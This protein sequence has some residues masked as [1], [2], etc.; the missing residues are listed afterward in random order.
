M[1]YVVNVT[2]CI[3]CLVTEVIYQFGGWDGGQDLADLWA[4]SV[5]AEQWTCISKNTAEEGG[6]S[7]RSCHKMCLDQDRKQIFTLGR[8]LDSTCR[9]PDNLKVL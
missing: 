5:P 8:Y 6:P 3:H 7:A 9:T 4:Y 1:W 2:R